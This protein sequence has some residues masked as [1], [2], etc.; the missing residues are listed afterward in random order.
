MMEDIKQNLSRIDEELRAMEEPPS[1]EDPERF[2]YS[3]EAPLEGR[4]ALIE[5]KKERRQRLKAEKKARKGKGGFGKF[6]L[7]LLILALI[8]WWYQCQM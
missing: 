4:A 8:G 6:L 3:D 2:V 5:T 7:F 1:F